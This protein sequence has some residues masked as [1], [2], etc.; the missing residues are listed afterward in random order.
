MKFVLQ[1]VHPR[2]FLSSS[3]LSAIIFPEEPKKPFERVVSDMP[4]TGDRAVAVEKSGCLS[5]SDIFDSN[6][7]MQSVTERTKNDCIGLASLSQRTPVID[8]PFH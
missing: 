3:P 8:I 6:P 1:F 2:I 4:C 7:A 5:H